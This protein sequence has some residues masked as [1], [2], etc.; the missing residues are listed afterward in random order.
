MIDFEEANKL[1]C[2]GIMRREIKHQSSYYQT[3]PSSC[4]LQYG[5]LLISFEG[6]FVL[7]RNAT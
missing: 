1:S 7:K 3:G 6:L 4:R 2:V 5:Q